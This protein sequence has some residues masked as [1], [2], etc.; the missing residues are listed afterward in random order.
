VNFEF[1]R[2]NTEDVSGRSSREGRS[3]REDHYKHTTD[4]Y[5]PTESNQDYASNKWGESQNK[6]HMPSHHRDNIQTSKS[7]RHPSGR[8]S[9]DRLPSGGKDR[10]SPT[11][12][13]RRKDSDIY[14]QR[15]SSPSLSRHHIRI[16]QTSDSPSVLENVNENDRYYDKQHLDPSTAATGRNSQNKRRQKLETMMF[17]N[18]SLSS[19]PSDCARPPPPKPHKNKRGKKTRQHSL[20]SSDDEIRSTPECSSGE[21]Q[22]SESLISEKGNLPEKYK[23]VLNFRAITISPVLEI[24]I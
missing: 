21:E 8:H 9:R 17:R 23:F 14:E 11:P 4:S 6:Q 18:D 12:S 15:V 19:D 16:E 7:E 24:K 3:G 10:R 20:S 2:G 5:H 22:E 13:D 1:F